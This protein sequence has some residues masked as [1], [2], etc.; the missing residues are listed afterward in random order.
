MR[1]GFVPDDTV[2]RF[3]GLVP[4]KW[5]QTPDRVLVRP[6]KTSLGPW[7]RTLVLAD[8]IGDDVALAYAAMIGAFHFAL[9]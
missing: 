4:Q 7:L 9:V 3:R 6:A 1:P 8:D 5:L 2:L